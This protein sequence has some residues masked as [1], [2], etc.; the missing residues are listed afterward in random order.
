MKKLLWILGCAATVA[1]ACTV[2][3]VSPDTTTGPEVPAGFHLE[4]LYAG[5]PAETRTTFD[6]ET[7]SFAWSE[8]DLLAFHLSD[9]SFLVSPVDPASGEVQ[10]IIKDGIVRDQ[11]AV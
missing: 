8:G 7:G 1:A 6:A 10:L 5:Y 3:T 4:T 9:G 11:F 2:E